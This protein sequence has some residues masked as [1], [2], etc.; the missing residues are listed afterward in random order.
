MRL[1]ALVG[2][3]CWGLATTAAAQGSV[4]AKASGGQAANSSSRTKAELAAIRELVQELQARTETVRDYLAQLR[5]LVEQRP[6]DADNGSDA[7]KQPQLAAWNTSLERLLRRIDA[8]RA[9]LADTEQRLAAMNTDRLPAA[10]TAN[11]ETA[12]QEAATER[13][14]AEQALAASKPPPG[15]TAKSAKQAPPPT[16]IP[17]L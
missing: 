6:R 14:S 13:T 5:S 3:M 4:S 9:K 2:L 7:A 17:D 11:V 1:A 8:A 12:R 10:L 15:H 16:D